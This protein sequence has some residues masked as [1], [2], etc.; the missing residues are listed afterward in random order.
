M[1]RLTLATSA[2]SSKYETDYG[3]EDP[4]S[5][6]SMD[7]QVVLHIGHAPD[8]LRVL[9][10]L[11]WFLR[12]QLLQML[13]R[14]LQL[15][16]M[17]LTRLELLVSLVQLGLEVVDVALSSDQHVLGVLQSG[18]GVIEE[19]RLHIAAAVGPHQLVIQFL[20]A[21]FQAVVLLK[22]LAVTLLDVLD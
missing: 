15:N 18:A 21:R 6:P 2:M 10:R 12:D 11:L 3:Y 7:N 8:L 17:S 14:V 16:G 1:P 13:D 4:C 20:D 9:L 5:L 19:A 22:K